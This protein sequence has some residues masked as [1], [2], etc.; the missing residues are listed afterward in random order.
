VQVL[1]IWEDCRWLT[2][3][4]STSYCPDGHGAAG[5]PLAPSLDK[6]MDC[7]GLSTGQSRRVMTRLSVLLLRGDIKW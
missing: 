7:Y 3:A 1:P 6:S 4:R 5:G 2:G